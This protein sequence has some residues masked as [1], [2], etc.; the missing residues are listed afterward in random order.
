MCIL[1]E[2]KNAR[3]NIL[4]YN[5]SIVIHTSSMQAFIPHNLI[6]LLTLDVPQMISLKTYARMGGVTGTTRYS[7]LS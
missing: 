6:N 1:K 5:F 3:L 7:K 4:K 2:I